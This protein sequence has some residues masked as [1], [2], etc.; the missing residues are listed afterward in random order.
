MK[1]KTISF[2]WKYLLQHLLCKR[3]SPTSL[4]Y[5]LFLCVVP[6]FVSVK[7]EKVP[8]F[9]ARIICHFS[10][11]LYYGYKYRKPF[12]INRI[13]GLKQLWLQVIGHAW[14]HFKRLR[15]STCTERGGSEKFKMKIYV[16]GGI[17]TQ[18]TPVHDKKVSTLEPLGHEGLMVISGLMSYRIMGY[19][20]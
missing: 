9:I 19:K 17:Q 3:I 18:A 14:F 7:I 2:Y 16:S 20:Y 13:W 1:I 8:T 6:V 12:M 10:L 11:K 4:I 15:W 5:T